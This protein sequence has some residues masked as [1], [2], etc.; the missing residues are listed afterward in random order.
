MDDSCPQC[1][2]R[3]I[4]KHEEA[5]SDRGRRVVFVFYR[6]VKCGRWVKREKTSAEGTT[7]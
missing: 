6:C 7:D 4:E 5:E 2:G 3:L 1:G